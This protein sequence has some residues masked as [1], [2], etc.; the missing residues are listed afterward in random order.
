MAGRQAQTDKTGYKMSKLRTRL[1]F[2]QI[3]LHH[4]MIITNNLTKII[5]EKGTDSV[6]TRTIH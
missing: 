3:N 4:S 2:L 6:Y 5:D 1:K